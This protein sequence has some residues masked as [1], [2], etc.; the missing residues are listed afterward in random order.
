MHTFGTCALMSSA[1][2]NPRPTKLRQ[3]SYHLEDL[4]GKRWDV[5]FEVDDNA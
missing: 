4:D 5:E 1:Y 2:S 3:S